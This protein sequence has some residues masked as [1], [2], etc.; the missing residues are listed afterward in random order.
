M[1]EFDK[2]HWL[3]SS[4]TGLILIG[5]LLL[6]GCTRT[7]TDY[8]VS[9]TAPTVSSE[10]DSAPSG[11]VDFA[12]IPNAIPKDLPKSKRG[13]HPYRVFGKRYQVM[14]S[15]E[16]FVER[17]M[18][19]WYGTKYHGRTTSSGEVYDMYAMTAAHRSLP[20]PTFV[21][22]TNLDNRRSIIV[23]IND[24]GPFIDNRVLD[25][26]YVA[27]GKLGILKKGVAPVVISVIN[28]TATGTGSTPPSISTSSKAKVAN[29]QKKGYR[30]QVATFTNPKNAKSLML[31]LEYSL[32]YP[33]MIRSGGIASR[34]LYQV[35]VGP[36]SFSE[37]E[38]ASYLLTQLGY[39]D[40]RLI[41]D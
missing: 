30:L 27:A 35:Q 34:P 26:S 22:V 24:R 9:R 6:H 19:S 8:S 20:L 28:P 25:L 1:T 41:L 14:S 12:A 40:T 10:V 29:Q 36:F 31:D 39:T 18:A 13:N 33:I 2:R 23:K 17:G 32:D 11:Y 15:S 38:T 4:L 7:P 21:R 3:R 5:S 16:N 37:L